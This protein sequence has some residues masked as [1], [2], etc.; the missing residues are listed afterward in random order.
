MENISSVDLA[1]AA[2]MMEDTTIRSD[3]EH[4]KIHEILIYKTLSSP[5]VLSSPHKLNNCTIIIP[6]HLYHVYRRHRVDY[7]F[8]NIEFVKIFWRHN[9]KE[10]D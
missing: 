8:A 9:P 10:I 3:K 1:A 7:E 4:Y 2:D 5:S 6:R